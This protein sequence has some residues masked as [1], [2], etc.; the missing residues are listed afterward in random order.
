MHVCAHTCVC[1]ECARIRVCTMSISVYVHLPR[2]RLC[3]CRKKCTCAHVCT[4]RACRHAIGVHALR[5]AHLCLH[6]ESSDTA[7]HSCTE[8]TCVCTKQ[9]MCLHGGEH[10]RM[11]LLP[12]GVHLCDVTPCRGTCTVCMCTPQLGHAHVCPQHVCVLA[13]DPPT[14]TCLHGVS[15]P[16]LSF[17]TPLP[18]APFA[19]GCAARMG[20]RGRQAAPA[21]G[22]VLLE[23]VPAGRGTHVHHQTVCTSLFALGWA[24]TADDVALS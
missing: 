12:P 8:R 10:V 19:N 5:G 16:A 3:V 18:C 21:T 24:A 20:R 15:K 7:L 4:S 13:P 23:D 14:S 1:T 22:K 9:R 6:R 11:P 2:A 17:I